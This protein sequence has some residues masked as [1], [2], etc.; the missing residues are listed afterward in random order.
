[1]PE[2]YLSYS[3]QNATA[4]SQVESCWACNNFTSP[5]VE[6]EIKTSVQMVRL[7]DVKALFLLHKDFSFLI[8]RLF[9]GNC[10]LFLNDEENRAAFLLL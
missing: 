7:E 10:R 6:I 1:L 3:A 4:T 5:G 8:E 9:P 2:S